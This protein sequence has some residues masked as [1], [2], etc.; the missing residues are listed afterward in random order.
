MISARVGCVA[1][2]SCCRK[3]PVVV[4]SKAFCANGVLVV[5]AAFKAEGPLTSGWEGGGVQPSGL[6]RALMFSSLAL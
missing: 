3:P 4:G 5:R 2:L 6:E 1:Y